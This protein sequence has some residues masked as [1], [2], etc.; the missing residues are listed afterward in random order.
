M[1]NLNSVTYLYLLLNINNKLFKIKQLKIASIPNNTVKFSK[2]S[3]KTMILKSLNSMD[4]NVNLCSHINIWP[5]Y[6]L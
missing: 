1:V 4:R 6:L 2:I 3:S 5:F